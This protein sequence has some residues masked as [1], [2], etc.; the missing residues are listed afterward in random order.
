MSKPQDFFG[1]S[2]KTVLRKPFMHVQDQKAYNVDGGSSVADAW[3]QRTLNTVIHNDIQGASLVSNQVSLPAGLYYV[4]AFSPHNDAA[5][6]NFILSVF[7]NGTK[8]VQGPSGYN[9]NMSF[10][11]VCGVVE[12]TSSGVLELR[13][14]SGSSYA[15]TGLGR[16]NNTGSVTD[17]SIP[18][19]YAD[20]KIWQ[21]DRSLEMA[22]KA[23]NS[24]L[25]TV[26]GLNTEGNIMGFDVTVAGNVLTITKGSCLDSTLEIPLAFTTD[27]TVT[28]PATV[29]QDFFIFA[30]RLTDGVTYEPRSYT[31][32]AGPAS[33]SEIDVWRFISYAKND[34]SGVTMPYTQTN[35]RIKWHVLSN[36]PVLASSTTS[37]YLPYNIS[38]VLPIAILDEVLIYVVL[39][40]W[41][42]Y[43]GTNPLWEMQPESVNIIAPVASVYIRWDSA[44]TI[45]SITGITLRR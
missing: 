21:L 17:T 16:S 7:V 38:S 4:E 20:L 35:G 22:P 2:P 10:A 5:A 13:Y 32:L 3:T 24:G 15:T 8:K 9:A 40:Q 28:L 29:N 1:S 18:S 19:I 43:D 37:A 26:A 25:Q 23:V 30:V 27:K 41:L 6:A 34:G 44:T 36:C 42:S 31:T 11:Q 12:L 45:V 33:D 39:A 14:Y